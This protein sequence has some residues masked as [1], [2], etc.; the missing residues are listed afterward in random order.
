VGLTDD[1]R[2]RPA[3]LNT[4]NDPKQSRRQR[5]L[6]WLSPLEMSARNRISPARQVDV[7]REGQE[8]GERSPNRNRT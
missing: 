5:P 4:T 6:P 1:R 2:K 3:P 8:T 7:T